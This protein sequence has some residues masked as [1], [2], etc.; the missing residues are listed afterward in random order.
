M[1]CLEQCL[2]DSWSSVTVS[3]YYSFLHLRSLVIILFQDANAVDL[4]LFVLFEFMLSSSDY[5]ILF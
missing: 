2:T 4:A 1:K 3:Y 5:Y